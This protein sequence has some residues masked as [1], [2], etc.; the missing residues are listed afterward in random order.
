MANRNPV[1]ELALDRPPSFPFGVARL[2]KPHEYALLLRQ[3][4][5]E[6]LG[7]RR[8]D[9]PAM[10]AHFRAEAWRGRRVAGEVVFGEVK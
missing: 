4:L 7:R 1:L 10:E 2:V 6:L 3:A 5:A 8:R 9:R